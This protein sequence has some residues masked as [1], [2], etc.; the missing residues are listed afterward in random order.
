MLQPRVRL[1]VKGKSKVSDELNQHYI[2]IILV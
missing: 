2:S 1:I